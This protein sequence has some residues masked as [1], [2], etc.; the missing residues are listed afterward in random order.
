[1]GTLLRRTMLSL[2]F[3]LLLSTAAAQPPQ[4]DESD[5]TVRVRM[6]MNSDGSRTTYRFNDAQRKCLA[7]TTTEDGKRRE[8]IRYELDDAGRFSTGRIFGPDGKLRFKSRY[9]YESG[10]RI[11]EETQMNE[12]GAVL[13]RIIYTYEQSGRPTGYS[14]FDGTGKLENRVVAPTPGAP[15][16][17]RG[18]KTKE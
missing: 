11:E 15:P 18:K 2:A 17:V 1:M 10:G 12:S 3:A 5:G 16:K 14:V 13:H 9:K 8:K 4:R 6:V 7:E